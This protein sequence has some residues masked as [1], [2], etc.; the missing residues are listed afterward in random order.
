MEVRF[1]RSGTVSRAQELSSQS[2][3]SGQVSGFIKC[4]FRSS[5][6]ALRSKSDW[7]EVEFSGQRLRSKF[8]SLK[9]EAEK[10]EVE[11]GMEVGLR[12]RLFPEGGNS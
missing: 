9:C 3:S 5:G 2:E 4:A 11:L 12:S 7:R 6:N 1:S 10:F 8:G